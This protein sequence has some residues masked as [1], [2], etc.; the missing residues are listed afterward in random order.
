M[1]TSRPKRSV[2]KRDYKRMISITIPQTKSRRTATSSTNQDA[3]LSSKHDNQ[4]YHLKIL[5]ED[6]SH[7]TVKVRYV[8]YRNECDEWRAMD[9][10]VD[11]NE[12]DSNVEQ[13]SVEGSFQFDLYTTLEIP[14]RKKYCLYKELTYTIKS[15]LV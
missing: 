2:P 6:P 8:G 13:D 9:D 4:L 10:I 3:Q 14:Q 15:L 11:L 5:E 12:D 7:G 1:T